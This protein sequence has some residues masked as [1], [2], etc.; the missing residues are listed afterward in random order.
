MT[1]YRFDSASLCVGFKGIAN[2]DA[3]VIDLEDVAVFSCDMTSLGKKINMMM[4]TMTIIQALTKLLKNYT[5]SDE[6]FVSQQHFLY[7]KTHSIQLSQLT[8]AII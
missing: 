7:F 1:K 6:N 3:L 2:F 8:K 4:M 5:A